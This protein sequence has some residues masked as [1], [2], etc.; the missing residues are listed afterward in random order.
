M[1]EINTELKTDVDE[2][3][4]KSAGF[5]DS[6]ILRFKKTINDYGQLLLIRSIAF[7]TAKNSKGYKLEITQENVQSSAHS[8]AESFGKP[9]EPKWTVWAQVFEYIL[10]ATA[11]FCAGKTEEKYGMIGFVAS[12]A[13]AVILFV[14]RQTRKK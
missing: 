12:T 8:I 9:D 11:G 10:T 14:T 6:G 3:Q 13:I 2:S 4:L 5:T 7:G 1:T